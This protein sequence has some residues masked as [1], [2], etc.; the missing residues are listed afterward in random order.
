MPSL[1][2][3]AGIA[4]S[5]KECPVLIAEDSCVSV[6]NRNAS[7]RECIAA[8]PFDVISISKNEITFDVA[9][10]VGCGACTTACPTEALAPRTPSDE[11]LLNTLV[12]AMDSTGGVAV[13][14]CARMAAKHIADPGRFAE[15]PCLAR[16][17]ESLLVQLAAAQADSVVLVD[18][19]CTTCKYGKVSAGI[20]ATMAYARELLSAHGSTLR[21]E[22]ASAYPNAV[23]VEDAASLYGSTRRGFFSDAASAAKETTVKAVKA[24]ID[25]ELGSKK[26]KR[27]LGQRLRIGSSGTM[28]LVHP[29]RHARIL[30]VLDA[31]GQPQADT[32]QTRLFATLSIDLDKCNACG[33]CVKFCPTGAL[34]RDEAEKPGQPV[35]FIEFSAN[36]CVQC[37]MCLDVC[38]KHAVT[39]DDAVPTAE[40][41]DFEPS[42]FVVDAI[43]R[44]KANQYGKR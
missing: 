23:I 35:R 3:I 13:V 1:G 38:W 24:T 14:S 9:A 39:L 36:D 34:M 41:F 43:E 40:L 4:A 10:C 11:D 22:R 44:K 42:T 16:I 8:C 20:D 33:M 26:D 12:H 31:L 30:D 21:I 29:V 19:T 2:N 5:L 32:V 18:G 15:V 17:D 6:R 37:G 27:G 28:P 25:H 7:C